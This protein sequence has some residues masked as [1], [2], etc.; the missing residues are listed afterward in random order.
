MRPLIVKFLKKPITAVIASLTAGLIVGAAVLAAAGYS[1]AE[2]YA[3][4]L[5]GIF[6]KPKYMSQVVI[7]SVPVVLTGLSVAFAYK[8]GLFNI[9][10]EGQ[11][12]VGTLAAAMLG[13]YLPLPPVLHPAFILLAAFL[14]G[15]LYGG[16]AG[17]L[18]T[19][20][21]IHEVISTIMLNWTALHLN[22]FILALPGV[23]KPGSQASY[24]ILS[25]ARL[26]ILG[27][28][29][30]TAAGRE[31]IRE[32]SVL[33]DIL[34]TDVHLGILFAVILVAA[35]WYFLNRTTKGYE[36][37]A[38]GAGAP[39]AEFAGIGI[40]KN[41]LTAMFISG[42]IAALGGALQIM[43]TNS[44]RISVLAS[45]EG[46]GWDG[47]SVALIAN[48]NP[49]GVILSG[50]LFSALRYGGDSIQSLLGAPSEV[51]NIMIGTIVFCIALGPALSMI[52]EKLKRR[53][54]D[55]Q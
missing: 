50:V 47:L 12:I 38:V 44:F 4:M 52:A 13:H 6:Q 5:A 51:I 19:K 2:A 7:N 42:G 49:F 33:G 25:S 29:K 17:W 43:G 39:A 46:Y 22:N 45:H 27:E 40:K 9:G 1:P 48:N 11:Y 35:A 20:F 55:G 14:L 30:R 31:F 34:R 41:M 28:W 26:R 10:V 53:C 3:A 23:K 24:E 32:H 21:G 37:R 8:T 36:L 54:Q 16:L 18:K 15:G